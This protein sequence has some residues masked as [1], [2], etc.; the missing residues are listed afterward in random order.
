MALQSKPVQRKFKAG[1]SIQIE[2]QDAKLTFYIIKEGKIKLVKEQ[3]PIDDEKQIDLQ[4][5]DFFGVVSCMAER[6]RI[7]TAYALTDVTLISVKKDQF[8]HILKKNPSVA[9]KI[10][11]YFSKRLRYYDHKLSEAEETETDEEGEVKTKPVD[12]P[13]G[14]FEIAECYNNQ[15]QYNLALYA[16]I[17]YT[18]YCPNGDRISEAKK[19]IAA[20]APYAKE[21]MNPQNEGDSLSKT[22]KDNTFIFCEHELGSELYV[23]KS[24][25]VKITK[26]NEKLEEMLIALLGEKEIFGEM[27]LLDKKPRSANA[28]ADGD[29]EL[30]SINESNF[31]ELV[32]VQVE[33]ALQLITKLSERVWTVYRQLANIKITDPVGRMLDALLIQLQNKKI[34][35]HKSTSYTFDFGPVE[36]TKMVGI[37]QQDG[38]KIFPKVLEN[39]Y[40]SLNDDKKIVVHDLTELEKDVN[41]YKKKELR[42]AKSKRKK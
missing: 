35:I 29:T 11:R 39:K 28:I 34:P 14:L 8:G 21:A 33:L 18:Q 20:I 31:E 3:E 24:G 13:E 15:K 27:A 42:Q 25:K 41:Y 37:P 16:Y 22:F 38:K 17:R 36:L 4:R 6:P 10:L 40:Y 12:D 19:K 2:G 7:E 26:V 32:K 1:T 5:G 30:M 9:M 23:I